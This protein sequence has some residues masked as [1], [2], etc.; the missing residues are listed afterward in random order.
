MGFVHRCC[1]APWVCALSAVLLADACERPAERAS[2]AS[3]PS[4]TGW[5]T[6][7]END[8]IRASMDTAGLTQRGNSIQVWLAVTDISIPERRASSSPFWRFETLQAVNCVGGQARGI[9]IRTP[10]SLGKPYNSPVNDTRWKDFADHG[11]PAGMLDRVCARLRG[12]R[13]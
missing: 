5:V 6:L 13:G 8:S 1:R 4:V 9:L 10:D 11:L 7:D 12:A 2:L 3:T